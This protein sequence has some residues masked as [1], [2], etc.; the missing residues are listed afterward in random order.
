MPS[1][2]DLSLAELEAHV[3]SLGA[4]KYRARQVWEWAYRHFAASYDEMANVP[5]DLRRQLAETLPFP[6]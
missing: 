1:L 2:Y 4:P 3:E 5:A 6:V